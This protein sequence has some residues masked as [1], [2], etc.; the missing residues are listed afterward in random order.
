MKGFILLFLAA[1]SML[2]AFERRIGL[3]VRSDFRGELSH[4]YRIQAA[5]KNIGW[6]ADV[7]ERKHSRKLKKSNYDFVINLAPIAYKHPKCKNYLAIFDPVHHYFDEGGKLSNHHSFYDGYLLT[8]AAD[9]FEGGKENF[10]HSS[11]SPCMRWYPTVQRR[12]YRKTD[13]SSLFYICCTWGDRFQDEKFQQLMSLLDKEPYMR[14][15][16]SPAV[17]SLYPQSYQGMIPYDSESLYEVAAEAGVVLVLHSSTHNAYGL[18][19]GRIFEAAASSAVIICDQNP[20]VREH[21]GDAVLYID[22]DRDSLQI[23]GQIQSHMNWI[24]ANKNE[25]LEKARRAHAIYNERF[26]L[27]DQLLQLGEFHDRLSIKPKHF[28]WAW[29]EAIGSSEM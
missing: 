29:L 21:F 14:F 13:P 9:S 16:G 5:C 19:S 17:Q 24:R 3:L 10:P 7:I 12:E 1:C 6:K 25:A 23:H 15:F 18:P 28:I 4:A 8:Y 2:H 11:G 20:F 27:E 22:T 26:L